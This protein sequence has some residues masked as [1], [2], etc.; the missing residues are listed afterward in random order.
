MKSLIILICILLSL[1]VFAD[2][3]PNLKKYP[4]KFTASVFDVV[5]LNSPV[6]TSTANFLLKVPAGFEIDKVKYKIKNAARILDKDNPHEDINLVNGPQGKE[7]RIPIS[8]LPPGCYQLF[9]KVVDKKE[10]REHDFRAAYHDYVRFVIDETLEVKMPDPKIDDSTVG[11]VDSDGDLIPDRIQRWINETYSDQKSKLVMR[12]AARARQLELLS[13][14]DKQQSIIASIK[15]L[16]SME[17]SSFVFGLDNMIKQDAKMDAKFLN[18]KARL[19]AE[20]KGN[21]NF[22]GQIYGADNEESTY[23]DFDP[24]I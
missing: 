21:Q 14:N 9:V 4:P 15:M 17:C 10:K 16:D 8:K 12:Q 6:K 7:L 18:T 19:E 1:S 3:K 24:N 2:Q 11:G 13:V 5:P 22:S 20:I 23:C